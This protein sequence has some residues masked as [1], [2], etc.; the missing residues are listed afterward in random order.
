M[1]SDMSFEDLME[2]PKLQNLYDA[3][4]SGEETV[5]ERPCWVLQ[6]V[7][8][9]GADP[10]YH[11]RRLWVDKERFLV[12]K[13]ERFA[14]SGKLLKTAEVMKIGQMGNRW[15]AERALFRD[16]LKSDG[17]TEF[18]ISAVEF[19]PTIPDSVFSQA[20]LRK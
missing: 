15:V 19:D 18:V 14:R 3:K 8:K 17:G 5:L 13:E 4:V 1:G 9:G 7:A 12:L 6:L 20:S 11:S 16:A 10:A 2:D